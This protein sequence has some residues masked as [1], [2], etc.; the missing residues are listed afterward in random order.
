MFSVGSCH[1]RLC[2][3]MLFK[4][5]RRSL[6]DLVWHVAKP[7]KNG[8]WRREKVPSE[9]RFGLSSPRYGHFL[10]S[11]LY[12]L[13]T[14]PTGSRQCV[15]GLHGAPKGH[16]THPVG[17]IA[18]GTR[19]PPP[20]TV[21]NHLGPFRAVWPVPAPFFFG[22]GAPLMSRTRRTISASLRAQNQRQRRAPLG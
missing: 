18:L 19:S 14:G 13:K 17:H 22:G 8:A 6:M 3:V 5:T 15:V 21:R 7:T 11:A 16:P 9:L 4:A 20:D 10:V 12:A 1:C 2:F